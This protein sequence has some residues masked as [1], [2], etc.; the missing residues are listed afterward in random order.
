MKMCL[1]G[2]IQILFEFVFGL[3]KSEIAN[4]LINVFGQMSRG[5]KSLCHI[6]RKCSFLLRQFLVG[7]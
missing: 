6:H 2:R 4:Q 1:Y 7:D 5:V 3:I